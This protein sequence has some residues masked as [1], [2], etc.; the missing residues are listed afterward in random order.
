[1][2]LWDLDVLMRLENGLGCLW[3]LPIRKTGIHLV[4]LTVLILSD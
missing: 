2:H 1:M 3:D 4:V